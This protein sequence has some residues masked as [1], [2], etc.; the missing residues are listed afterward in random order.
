MSKVNRI[1]AIINWLIGRL[2]SAVQHHAN[3]AA[4]HQ[5]QSSFHDSEVEA[6]MTEA[7][8]A[9]RIASNFKSLVA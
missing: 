3:K 1:L 9:A 4:Y 8:R 2:E 5:V 6:H 7:K